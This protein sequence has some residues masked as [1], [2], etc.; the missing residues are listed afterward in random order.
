MKTILNSLYS[1]THILSDTTHRTVKERTG[2]DGENR[3]GQR[4]RGRRE[5][6]RTESIG[7]EERRERRESMAR[8]WKDGEEGR[9][10]TRGTTKKGEITE[11]RWKVVDKRMNGKWRET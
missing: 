6:G 2:K 9:T 5:Q 11:I 4:V 1:D 8:R 7:V 10:E 3:E